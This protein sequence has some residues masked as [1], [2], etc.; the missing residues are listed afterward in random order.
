MAA[1]SDS[2]D[3]SN[4]PQPRPGEWIRIGFAMFA[5]GFGANLFAPML[6]VYRA[7]EGTS[8]SAVTGMLGVYAL[9]LVPALLYFG[10]VSDRFGRA[11]VLRLAMVF[12]AVGSLILSAA[13]GQ[14]WVL[15]FGRFIAGLAVGMAMASGAAWIKQ[16]CIDNPAAGPRRATVAVSAGF[17]IG[18][19]CAGLVA[20]FLPYPQV[21][22][23]LIHVVL[24]VIVIPVMWQVTE[25]QFRANKPQP[26]V[27]I[28]AQA[29]IKRF[30]WAVAAWAPWGFGTVTL[31]FA[32]L[33]PFAQAQHPT[34]FIGFAAATALL[35]GVTVQPFAARL[36]TPWPLAIT[37]LATA[38]IGLAVAALMVLTGNQWILFPAA[39]FLGTSYGIMMVSGLKEV[40]DIAGASDLG[41]LI[42]IFYALTYIGFFVPFVLSYSAPA[43]AHIFNT[44]EDMGFVLCLLFGAVVCVVS[45]VPVAKV[46]Q[47]AHDF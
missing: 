14:N 23:Y 27:W 8:H 24:A 5:I 45:M 43:A 6:Q 25:T 11:P 42:G 19:L 37:G 17:G 22:P 39:F 15:F 30:F 26:R 9:G 7:F 16:L 29:K 33:P 13:Q 20:E 41:A 47:K 34:V 10:P 44:T 1:H 12:S 32:S 46:A 4:K 28:P 35:S 36:R 21:V 18:P 40:E 38:F 2:A 31:A 3:N